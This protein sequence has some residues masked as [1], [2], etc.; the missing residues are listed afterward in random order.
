MNRLSIDA[1]LARACLPGQ[2]ELLAKGKQFF[3]VFGGSYD[4]IQINN[5]AGDKL[6]E[7]PIYRTTA[8]DSAA[9]V[10]FES[11][12][13]L[14]RR[15]RALVRSLYRGIIVLLALLTSVVITVT[16]FF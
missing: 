7:I 5:A 3:M 10:L 16:Y 1:S 11:T 13:K 9:Y 12:I 15:K 4:S 8:E 6:A 14:L 2:D